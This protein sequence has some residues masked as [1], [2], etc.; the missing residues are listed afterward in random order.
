MRRF[1][2]QG[3]VTAQVPVVR[4]TPA[5]EDVV[6]MENPKRLDFAAPDA[7]STSGS[8]MVVLL[9]LMCTADW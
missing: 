6:R 9:V 8:K 2:R 3:V 7:A 1:G 5:P 4:T